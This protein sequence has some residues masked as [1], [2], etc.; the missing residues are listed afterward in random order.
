MNAL[1]SKA[2]DLEIDNEVKNW[3]KF[4]TERDVGRR[5]EDA[6]RW[7]LPVETSPFDYY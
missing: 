4:A 1:T 6:P 2:S 3:L 5:S 7:S